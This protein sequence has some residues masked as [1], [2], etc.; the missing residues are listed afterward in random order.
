ML[1]NAYL[2]NR[3]DRQLD[4]E[5][6]EE[7][8]ESRKTIDQLKEREEELETDIQKAEEEKNNIPA[9]ASVPLLTSIMDCQP[10]E[11]LP[12][13][14]LYLDNPGIYFTASPIL[15]DSE[16]NQRIID[17]LP[18][19]KNADFYAQL[20]YL[21]MPYYQQNGEV[22]VGE[23]VVRKELSQAVLDSFLELFQKKQVFPSMN[24]EDNL[25]VEEE[26]LSN[27]LVGYLPSDLTKSN[28]EEPENAGAVFSTEEQPSE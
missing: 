10:G 13:E 28:I 4:E 27:I 14:S 25:W 5:F 3:D 1:R 21:K 18:S 19:N 23:M 20:R 8:E 6:T 12:E 7:L 17:M 11:V 26:N 9:S 22:H 24:L 15:E 2:L 16:K